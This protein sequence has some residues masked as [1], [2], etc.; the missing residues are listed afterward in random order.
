[1]MNGFGKV[2]VYILVELKKLDVVYYFK[3]IN[4]LILYCG[5]VYIVIL[6]FDELLK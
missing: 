2:S 5:Y 1:M 3:D 4:G 6:I